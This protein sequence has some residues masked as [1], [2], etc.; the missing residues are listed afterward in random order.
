MIGRPILIAVVTKLIQLFICIFWCLCECCMCTLKV[1][2]TF[3]VIVNMAVVCD[4][5]DKEALKNC[6]RKKR[7]CRTQQRLTYVRTPNCTWYVVR[8]YIQRMNLILASTSTVYAV[9][10]TRKIIHTYNT[11]VY[12]NAVCTRAYCTNKNTIQRKTENV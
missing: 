5:R 7:A 12:R 8:I 11:T 2:I 3:S 6:A 9:W 10:Y 1:T 4:S